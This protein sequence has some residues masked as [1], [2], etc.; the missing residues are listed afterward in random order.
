M[1]EFRGT[2]HGLDIKAI[3]IDN[4]LQA[5]LRSKNINVIDSDFFN[6][7]RNRPV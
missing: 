4:D 1:K 6:I 7:S 3:E 5:I 2:Y